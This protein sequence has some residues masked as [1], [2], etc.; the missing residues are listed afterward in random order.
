MVVKTK[1]RVTPKIKT[2]AK[3]LLAFAQEKAKV[4]NY[5]N[6]LFNAIFGPKGQATIVF[7]DESER[8]AF[9]RTREYREIRKL[10][11]GLPMPA[12]RD[13]GDLLAGADLFLNLRV[14]RSV[15]ETLLAEAAV[16]GVTMEELCLS[17]LVVQLR[18]IV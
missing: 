8:E 3:Q 4:C 11:D 5:A 15:Y 10:E 18:D 2:K 1:A 9:F 16:E 13:V 7:P 17:K 12:P 14:P 6:E